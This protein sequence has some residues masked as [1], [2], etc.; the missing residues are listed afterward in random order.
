MYWRQKQPHI[1]GHKNKS[2]MTQNHPHS[3]RLTL[4]EGR[5]MEVG[6]KI[7]VKEEWQKMAGEE[8]DFW[9]NSWANKNEKLTT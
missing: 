1:N 6:I 9:Q 2:T 5:S 7:C 8:Q 4:W 3:I